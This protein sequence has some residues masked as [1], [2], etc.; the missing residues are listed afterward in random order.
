[1]FTL[2]LASELNGGNCNFEVT[3]PAYPSLDEVRDQAAAVFKEECRRLGE[4]L[5]FVLSD[6]NCLEERE[7]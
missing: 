3:F 4:F 2:L 5:L 6:E 1:M 7:K